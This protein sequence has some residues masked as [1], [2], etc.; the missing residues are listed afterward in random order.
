MQK[1]LKAARSRAGLVAM[2][3]AAMVLGVSGVAGAVP[4]YDV[5]PVT[6]SI[7]SELAAN[8]PAVLGIVGGIIALT[9]AIK[10]VRKFVHV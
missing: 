3:V 5:T 8:L 1:C 7:T 2:V 6:T 4:V 9:I 10:A